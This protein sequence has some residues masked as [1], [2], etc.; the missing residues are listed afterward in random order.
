MSDSIVPEGFIADGPSPYSNHIGPFYYKR[1]E[2]GPSWVGIP[3]QDHHVGGNNRAHGGL[4]LTILD[5]A[6]GINAAFYRDRTPVVTVSLQTNFIGPM[7]NGNFLM[8]TAEITHA[9]KTM[10]FVE[11][12]AWCGEELVG[13][14]SGV[15]KYLLNVPKM[16][17]LHKA[18]VAS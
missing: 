17:E 18:K 5:E 3:L 11:G 13:S 9:T 16:P 6:M 15:F 10:A 4:L 7:L 14:A 12:K 8:A 2:K 1:E